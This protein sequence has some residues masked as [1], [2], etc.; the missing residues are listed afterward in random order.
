MVAHVADGVVAFK[1]RQKL[2]HSDSIS[3]IK[4]VTPNLH[5][6][7]LPICFH[8]VTI[9]ERLPANSAMNWCTRCTVPS[10][11]GARPSIKRAFA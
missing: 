7:H 1:A 4:K 5:S 9:G 10:V 2:G 11:S 8:Y 3:Y 6:P